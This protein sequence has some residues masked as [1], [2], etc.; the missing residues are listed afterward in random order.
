M[1][2]LELHG[3]YFISGPNAGTPRSRFE[4]SHDESSTPH[5]HPDTGPSAF[6]IDQDEWFAATGL[7]G[8][9][10]KKFTSRPTGEQFSFIPRTAEE[11]T[12]L[13]IV[14]PTYTAEHVRAGISREQHDA[15]VAA[16]RA[17][18]RGEIPEMEPGKP[19]EGGAA[20]ARMVLAFGLTPI[21]EVDR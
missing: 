4:H 15:C 11:Q 3:H 8:G 1:T 17:A 13:V 9:A 2:G 5:T 20:V 21:Y 12:F 10:R 6:T 14:D 16:A 18:E 19:S 7:K